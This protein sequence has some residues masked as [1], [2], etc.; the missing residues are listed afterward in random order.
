MLAATGT[1]RVLVRR[2]YESAEPAI[3]ITG[4]VTPAVRALVVDK[5]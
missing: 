4:P 5:C 3:P 1:T 2:D